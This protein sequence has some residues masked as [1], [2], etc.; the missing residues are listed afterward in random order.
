M[1]LFS[2]AIPC[3]VIRLWKEKTRKAKKTVEIKD[4]CKL[5]LLFD[6]QIWS[7]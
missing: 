7:P 6:C 5:L 2:C 1:L 3:H 4:L